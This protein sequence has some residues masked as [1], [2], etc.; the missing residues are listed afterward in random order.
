MPTDYMDYFQPLP[1]QRV[2]I[3]DAIDI[4]TWLLLFT[5][6]TTNNLYTN[7]VPFF[8]VANNVFKNESLEK[9]TDWM[10]LISLLNILVFEN[11]IR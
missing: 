5:L 7:S 11:Q 8:V 10:A 3:E 2:L 4:I 1:W 6:H 9:Q